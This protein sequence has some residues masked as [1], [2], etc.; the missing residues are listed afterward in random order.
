MKV[1][2]TSPSFAKYDDAPILA[3]KKA[4]LE[5]PDMVMKL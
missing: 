5:L 3:L 1:I 2:C 4:D